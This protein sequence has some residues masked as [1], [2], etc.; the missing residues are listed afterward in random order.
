[1]RAIMVCAS[2]LW[3][4]FVSASGLFPIPA[5]LAPEVDF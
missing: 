2:L 3:A 1:M 5:E 4:A